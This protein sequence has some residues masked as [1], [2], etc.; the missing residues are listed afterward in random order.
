MSEKMIE[1]V[2]YDGEYPN[3]CRGTLVIRLK[4][5][6]EDFSCD[7]AEDFDSSI[8]EKHVEFKEY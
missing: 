6:V 1:F 4:E 5:Y 2:S 7:E 8:E 3:L